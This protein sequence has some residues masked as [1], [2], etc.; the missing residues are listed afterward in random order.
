MTQRYPLAPTN[1]EGN[2]YKDKAGNV[3]II[4][5]EQEEKAFYAEHKDAVRVP[6]PKAHVDPSVEIGQLRKANEA[7]SKENVALREENDKLRSKPEDGSSAG[8]E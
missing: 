8:E 6:F 1:K 2:H 4:R 3:I 7:L 5:N